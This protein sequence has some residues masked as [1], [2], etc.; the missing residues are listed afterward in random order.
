MS[1][2]VNDASS[3]SQDIEVLKVIVDIRPAAR[4]CALNYNF[5]QKV[6]I[7]SHILFIIRNIFLQICMVN[8]FFCLLKEAWKTH[9]YIWKYT[10]SLWRKSL[11]SGNTVLSSFPFSTVVQSFLFDVVSGTRKA[12]KPIS[13]LVCQHFNT[14]S[15][16]LSTYSWKLGL[17]NRQRSE[18][19]PELHSCTSWLPILK[20][21]AQQLTR[22][23]YHQ[24][25]ITSKKLG[26]THM[27]ETD[28]S[29]SD[30]PS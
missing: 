26:F 9:F 12:S 18:W 14:S 16:H 1:P 10:Q 24:S 13:A 17:G 6:L 25:Q 19:H 27:S 15:H 8:F 22:N 30:T 7:P 11:S 3:S 21:T 4:C 29:L 23:L 5:I 20:P 2:P 28:C